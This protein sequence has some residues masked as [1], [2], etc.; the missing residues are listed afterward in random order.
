MR[1]LL[2]TNILIPREDHRV[3]PR[4]LNE[5][6]RLLHETGSIILLHP[7]TLQDL[8]HDEDEDRR[9]IVRSKLQ[10][11]ARLEDPPQYEADLEFCR[12]VGDC[13]KRNDKVDNLLL[14]A[15]YRNSVNLFVTEDRKLL[16]KGNHA[17][18]GGR[19]LPIS[20][21]I[22]LLWRLLPDE[23]VSRPAALRDEYVYNLDTAD[24]F[25]DSLKQGYPKFMN[26]IQRIA[27]EGRKCWV[28]SISQG[29]IGAL[30]VRKIEEEPI[31]RID[32]PLPKMRRLKL[33][34]FKVG[35]TGLRIGELF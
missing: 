2:D 9:S 7:A 17:G 28:Y 1:V 15:V 14:Y 29:R 32:S 25:F 30:L 11:Y 21:A 18:L 13:T 22:P 19:V 10:S 26:W 20:D 4:D 3:I 23:D 33:C 24:T 6:L 35:A 5:M 31:E 16:S 27:A 8:E 12:V 34:T